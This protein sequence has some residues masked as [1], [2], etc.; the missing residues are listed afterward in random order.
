MRMRLLGKADDGT[1]RARGRRRGEVTRR[2]LELSI[3]PDRTSRPSESKPALLYT[4]VV[5]CLLAAADPAA[6]R[7]KRPAYRERSD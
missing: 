2:G 4:V 6:G 3:T 5:T 1:A 7:E